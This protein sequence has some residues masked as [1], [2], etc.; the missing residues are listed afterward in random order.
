LDKDY[1][2]GRSNGNGFARISSLSISQT[3]INCR[4]LNFL[5]LVLIVMVQ[6][7]VKS[8]PDIRDSI[9]RMKLYV[10]FLIWYELC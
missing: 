6:G 8:C 3:S 9:F 5:Q 1:T 7:Q 10:C 4:N 2:K